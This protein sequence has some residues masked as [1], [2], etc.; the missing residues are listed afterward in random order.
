M[1]DSAPTLEPLADGTGFRVRVRCGKA[2]NRY[3]I[4]TT[5]RDLAATRAAVLVE[6]GQLLA[7]APAPLA[8]DLLTRAG[9]A[10]GPGLVRIQKAA[11][12]LADGAKVIRKAENPRHAW[13]V[14]DLGSAWTKG[15]LAKDYPDQIKVRRSA[16]DDASR[17]K[18]HVYPWVGSVRVA[19]LTLDDCER[20][21]RALPARLASNTRRNVALTLARLLKLAVYPLRLI[22]A[23]PIPAG[24]LPRM[25]KA[26]AL[27]FLY[28]D[29]DRALLR[30]A[31][32][33]LEFRALCGFTVRE[34]IRADEALALQWRDVDLKRGVLT[35]DRNKTDDPRAWA[36]GK[37]VVRA[38]KKLRGNAKGE[39][40]VFSADQPSLARVLR[41][42]LQTAKVKRAELFTTTDER[43]RLRFHDLR[44]SF[45]TVALANGQTETWV[46]DR[47]GHKSTAMIARYKRAAR[48]AK[49]ARLGSWVA[50]DVALFG[51]GVRGTATGTDLRRGSDSNR[52]VTV[53]QTVA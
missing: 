33:P 40:L 50:L 19:A 31:D 15:D 38:L 3:R 36:L 9:A 44:G 30:C 22:D 1:D 27:N 21:M 5:D 18:T 7:S 49:E 13:T 37:D 10:D 20:V 23:T 28:P 42:A 43:Q 46:A 32:V 48:T 24:F 12:A 2:R 14:E 29:E 35:L 25:R 26:R 52:R 4:P 41:K 11:K 47:T 6:L 39:A 34:G 45:V 8:H 17:L 16:D 51:K 53:L